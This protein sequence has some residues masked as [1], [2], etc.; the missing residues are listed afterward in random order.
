MSITAVIGGLAVVAG[1]FGAHALT[2]NLTSTSLEV[3]KTAVFYQFIH[4]LAILALNGNTWTKLCWLIG[5]FLFSGSLY[6]LSTSTLHGLAISWL[7]PITPL[8]GLFFILGWLNFARN[9]WPVKP[10]NGGK[11]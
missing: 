1:A 8:G 6:A 4:V 9:L 5:I 11:A 2:N 7:G 3:W 10:K